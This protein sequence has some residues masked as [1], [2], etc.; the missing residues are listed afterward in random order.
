M[1]RAALNEGDIEGIDVGQDE[2]EGWL[3]GS[4]DGWLVLSES[5]LE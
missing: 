4:E 1:L 5:E 2:M 3:L